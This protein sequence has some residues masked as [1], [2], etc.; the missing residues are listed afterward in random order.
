VTL[1]VCAPAGVEGPVATA[2]VVE[3]G[4]ASGPAV[5]AGD[6]VSAIKEG[7]P[8]AVEPTLSEEVSVKEAVA[9]RCTVCVAGASASV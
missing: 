9:P 7:S 8:T 1:T 3:P 4:R 6:G 5:A 2:T